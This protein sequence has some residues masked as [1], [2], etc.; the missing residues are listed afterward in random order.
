M[1]FCLYIHLPILHP[2]RWSGHLQALFSSGRT[3]FYSCIRKTALWSLQLM[4]K[5][6]TPASNCAK[7]HDASSPASL[8]LKKIKLIAI[9][10]PFL[11]GPI[12]MKICKVGT[13]PGFLA[14]LSAT[15]KSKHPGI[16]DRHSPAVAC[17]T[18]LC[19][20]HFVDLICLKEPRPASLP[21]SSPMN[22]LWQFRHTKQGSSAEKFS[23]IHTKW[24]SQFTSSLMDVELHYQPKCL[25]L[26]VTASEH[27]HL[28]SQCGLLGQG[29]GGIIFLDG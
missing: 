29:W 14:Q 2:H 5:Q 22:V 1:D 18:H 4:S 20:P 3:A 21:S 12:S 6:S 19:F 9:F 8:Y 7:L 24:Q 17:S 25:V 13:D 23:S 10:P 26:V 16:N 27:T 28:C 11:Y 15:V